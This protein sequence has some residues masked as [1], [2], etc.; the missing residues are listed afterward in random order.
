MSEIVK[1]L[2][3]IAP[4]NIY[5]R[6]YRE[7]FGYLWE[8]DKL[9]QNKTYIIVWDDIPHREKNDVVATSKY[10]TPIDW[11]V[12]FSLA[13]HDKGTAEKK[14]D[15][16]PIYPDLRILILDLNSQS[17]S[18]AD[19]V[20]FVNQSKDKG[21]MSMPWIRLYRPLDA[22]DFIK[23]LRSLGSVSSMKSDIEKSDMGIIRNVWAAFLTKPSTPGDQHA[24]ANLVGPLLLMGDETG[25]D[26]HTKALRSLMEALGLIPQKVKEE[27][28]KKVLLSKENPWI[29]WDT[30]KLEKVLKEEGKLNLILIDDQYHPGWGEVLCQAVGL[31]YKPASSA[32]C[33]MTEIGNPSDGKVTVKASASAEFILDLL[34]GTDQRFNFNIC[35]D[36]AK[37]AEILFL[38]LRLFSGED[39]KEQERIFFKRLV[40]IAEKFIDRQDLPWPGFDSE[41]LKDVREWC[42][43]KE[44]RE[45][46]PYVEALTLLPRILSLTDM[47]LPIVIFSST[48]RRDIAETLKP[49]GNII[50]DFDKPKFTVDMP[51]D[52]AEQTK[53][54]FE[55]AL[56]KALSILHG[57][58]VCRYVQVLGQKAKS[59]LPMKPEKTTIRPFKHVEIY[60]DESGRVDGSIFSVGGLVLS[61]PQYSDVQWL[62]GELKRS[63]L[64]WYSTD[65]ADSHFLSKEPGRGRG[66]T[67]WKYVA[68]SNALKTLCDSRK[69]N[70]AAVRLNEN[71][72]TGSITVPRHL[73]LQDIPG[74]GRYIRLLSAVL[75]LVLFE[76][77]PTWIADKTQITISIF[78]GTR[79]LPIELDTHALL[80][81]GTR[82]DANDYFGYGMRQFSDPPA[83]YSIEAGSIVRII[84][85]ILKS[86]IDLPDNFIVHH[87]RGINLQYGTPGTMLSDEV[88]DKVKKY[89]SDES[90]LKTLGEELQ[91]W[92]KLK[93]QSNKEAWQHLRTQSYYA[94]HVVKKDSEKYYSRMFEVGFDEPLDDNLSKLL[95]AARNIV[96]GDVV[97]AIQ[98]VPSSLNVIHKMKGS[99]L[100]KVSDSLER[101]DGRKFIELS[102]I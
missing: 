86:R 71:L 65:R 74:D 87:T 56:G 35:S 55:K 76:L 9:P 69:I 23:H 51:E 37:D 92:D 97:S 54:K 48:G 12:A 18:N 25:A 20:R 14:E 85:E 64:Y 10:L 89:V 42:K 52:I 44:K 50:T 88:M 99:L 101:L 8:L 31:E 78:C 58:N 59:C 2:E 67:D 4:T 47:S 84:S 81:D 53:A 11:A 32:T 15:G 43:N 98:D 1:V 40:E 38:D 34:D 36:P 75:E 21:I 63:G 83:F 30:Q 29:T 33:G 19:S 95:S 13:V 17:V 68:A 41:K 100:M 61:Y 39:K 57:R 73:P 16:K 45:T 77:I 46:E 102:G 91:S 27:E 80:W 70:I 90:K 3:Q 72:N 79:T 82:E 6:S 28:L 7:S 60:L 49:Y 62:S 22:E 94:D 26:H 96:N 24:I 5:I 66:K 93:K